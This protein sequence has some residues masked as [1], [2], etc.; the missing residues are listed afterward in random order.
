METSTKVLWIRN[1][2][3]YNETVTSHVLGSLAGSQW[4]LLHWAS[5]P[6]PWNP[7]ASIDALLEEQF[8]ESSSWSGLKRRS[9]TCS[10][11]RSITQVPK[12]KKKKKKKNKSMKRLRRR[13]SGSL[14]RDSVEWTR[15]SELMTSDERVMKDDISLSTS[16]WRAL[17]SWQSSSLPLASFHPAAAADTTAACQS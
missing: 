11:L 13:Q 17:T 9:H 2:S 6:P 16:K 14:L 7:T 5:W 4:A 8:L 10:F 3:A 15:D 1:R 12:K